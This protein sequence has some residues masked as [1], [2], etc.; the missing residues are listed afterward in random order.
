MPDDPKSLFLLKA[1]GA[2]K[3]VLHPFPEYAA[4]EAA[5]ESAWGQ[6]RLAREGNN[7][8]GEKQHSTPIYETLIFN[9]W[10]DDNKDGRPEPG[11][12]YPSCFV[13]F[14][15]W[16]ASFRS[17]LNTIMRLGQKQNSKGE[18][19]YPGYAA[20]LKSMTGEEFV[21]EVSKNWSTDPLRAEKVLAIY[22]H[23]KEV[24]PA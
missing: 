11:E 15:D 2:A 10:E 4:C 24:F 23:H 12:Y 6:S 18:Y 14:P 21:R 19:E 3:D 5:L 1:Y 22:A 9:A 20:A 16:G 8:F 7:L 17:R 13:K